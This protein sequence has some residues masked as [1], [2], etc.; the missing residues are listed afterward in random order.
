MLLQKHQHQ[1]I[2]KIKSEY[3]CDLNDLVNVMEKGKQ[4]MLKTASEEKNHM[5]MILY[6][7]DQITSTVDRKEYE[8]YM[9]KCYEAEYEE[10]IEMEDQACRNVSLLQVFDFR[11]GWKDLT[12][13]LLNVFAKLNDNIA[14][15]NV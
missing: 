11:E 8:D 5:Q 1:Y 3:E 10:S 15:R 4:E 6:G 13:R 7:Q 14:M 12:P 2:E 9:Q